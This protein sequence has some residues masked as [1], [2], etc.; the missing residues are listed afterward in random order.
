MKSSLQS[1]AVVG[2]GAVGSF[3]GAMLARGGHKATLVGR[4]AHV[5][6]SRFSFSATS[7]AV[8]SLKAG[9]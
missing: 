6:N 7:D 5:N 3:F 2:A 8:A 9:K 1:T 4:A